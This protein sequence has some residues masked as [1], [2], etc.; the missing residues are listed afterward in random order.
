MQATEPKMKSICL[1][2]RGGKEIS[3]QLISFRANRN[4]GR[5]GRKILKCPTSGCTGNLAV[6]DEGT[7]VEIVRQP[8]NSDIKCQSYIK[9]AKCKR[10]TGIKYV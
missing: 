1:I 4:S 10:E 6:I 3:Y 8:A 9:C 2:L 5:N 7:T